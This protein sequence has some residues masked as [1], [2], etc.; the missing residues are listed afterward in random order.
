MPRKRN[1]RKQTAAEFEQLREQ[2]GFQ[3]L[4]IAE[5]FGFSSRTSRRYK[6][7][8]VVVPLSTLILMRL[9]ARGVVTKRQVTEA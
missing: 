5:L 1:S 4:E 9:M 8:E 6:S 7:G 2:L 3:Q